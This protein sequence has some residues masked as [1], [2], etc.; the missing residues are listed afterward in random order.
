MSG[1]Q[2]VFQFAGCR[3]DFTR[4]HGHDCGSTSGDQRSQFQFA[5]AIRARSP[6]SAIDRFN[7]IEHQ[8]QAI[9]RQRVTSLSQL[10]DH[11][12]V[13]EASDQLLKVKDKRPGTTDVDQ[14]RCGTASSLLGARQIQLQILDKCQF[15]PLHAADVRQVCLSHFEGRLMSQVH[16]EIATRT[17]MAT[18]L[19]LDLLNR[20][21]PVSRE[22]NILGPDTEPFVWMARSRHTKELHI[23][24][25]LPAQHAARVAR[26]A[27][28]AF[29]F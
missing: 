2:V 8:L 4:G 20:R 1:L 11:D 5:T 17:A 12:P 22:L 27:D 9:G 7:Q 29:E 28:L 23:A 18:E 3:A 13:L 10:L 16:H 6:R 25:Q 21:D 19:K 26:P 24:L 15:Q 14:F